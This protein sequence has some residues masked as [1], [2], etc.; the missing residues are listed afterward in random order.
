MDLKGLARLGRYPFAIDIA[1][2]LFE[3]GGIVELRRQSVGTRVRQKGLGEES[4]LGSHGRC[5]SCRGTDLE[6]SRNGYRQGPPS[7][8][9]LQP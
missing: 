4:H 5:E 7:G 6:N 9:K 3:E 1:D 8:R 2:I